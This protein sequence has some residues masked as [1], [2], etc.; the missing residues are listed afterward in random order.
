MGLKDLA[1]TEKKRAKER[2]GSVN[3][4]QRLKKLMAAKQ[5]GEAD[6]GTCTGNLLRDVVCEITRTG[7]AVTI[8]LSRDM[9]AHSLTLLLDGERETLWFKAS[10]DLDGELNEIIEMLKGL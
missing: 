7:G 8:G 1:D 3:N 5:G 9:G 4:K 2:R 10:A 6:W